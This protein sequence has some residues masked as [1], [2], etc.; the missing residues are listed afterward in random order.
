[1][2]NERG[3]VVMVVDDSKTIRSSAEIFL[4]PAGYTVVSAEDG[5][6]AL[7]AVADFKP[8]LIFMD[9]S[10]DRL[11]GYQ[12]CRMIK[13]NEEYKDIPI[14]MLTSRDGLFDKAR[15]LMVG[16]SEYITKPFTKEDLLAAVRRHVEA[17]RAAA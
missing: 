12:A 3:V 14:V 16:S 5:F 8:D 13:S 17:R 4:S 11:D 9:V 6:A 7:A 10:M 15:G 1:M 2:G